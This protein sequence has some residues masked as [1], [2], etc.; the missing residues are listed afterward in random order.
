MITELDHHHHWHLHPPSSWHCC[1]HPVCTP[2]LSTWT[3]TLDTLH[4]GSQ[5]S[6]RSKLCLLPAECGVSPHC[7]Q[8]QLLPTTAC[9]LLTEGVNFEWVLFLTYSSPA[10]HYFTLLLLPSPPICIKPNAME[11]NQ[12]FKL[13]ENVEI[14]TKGYKLSVDKSL[15]SLKVLIGKEIIYF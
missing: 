5:R 1:Q 10:P 4:N 15:A 2:C 8:Q 12:I 14:R 7:L 3:T 6:S 11:G 13:K 9:C